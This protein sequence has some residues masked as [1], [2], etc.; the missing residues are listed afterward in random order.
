MAKL[1]VG[2]E[3]FKRLDLDILKQQKKQISQDEISKLSESLQTHPYTINRIQEI[4]NFS[5]SSSYE[6]LISNIDGYRTELNDE[7]NS[8]EGNNFDSPPMTYDS[9]CI[10]CGENMP[11]EYL[12]CLNCGSIKNEES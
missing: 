3:L 2:K 1:A 6:S 8:D 5:N 11:S 10:E 4:I 12:I 7:I 9:F